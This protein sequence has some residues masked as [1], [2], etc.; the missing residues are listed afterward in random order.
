[1]NQNPSIPNPP[2]LT[3]HDQIKQNPKQF[4]RKTESVQKPMKQPIKPVEI[5]QNKELIQD[6][7]KQRISKKN[8]TKEPILQK[9]SSS[10][11]KRSECLITEKSTPEEV[12]LFLESKEFS[13]E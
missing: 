9:T 8:F 12:K 3:L 4:L 1:M 7:I 11:I 10:S 6:E 5:K 13:N 2:V